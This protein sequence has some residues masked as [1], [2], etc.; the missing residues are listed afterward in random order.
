[1]SKKQT[2]KVKD[3]DAMIMEEM[4]RMKKIEQIKT[5][6]ALVNE[7]LAKL[8]EDGIDEVEVGGTKSGEQWYEK[9]TP[10]AKFEKKGSHLKEEDPTMADDMGDMGDGG[11]DLGGEEE[12]APETFEEKLASI[13]RELDAKL[14]GVGDEPAMDAAPDAGEE[15]IDLDMGDAATEEPAGD[16]AAEEIEVDATED[17]DSEEEIEID[18]VAPAIAEPEEVVSEE[19]KDKEAKEECMDEQE[20]PAM[21]ESKAPGKKVNRALEEEKKRMRKLAGL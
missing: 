8:N 15:D 5:R 7:E 21:N 10:V 9:G 3:I 13:G 2:I 20:K 1:M 12:L 17:G 16:E 6:L 11:L 18:E 4:V 19:K 14:A